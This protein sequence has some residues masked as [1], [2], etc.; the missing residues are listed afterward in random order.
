MLGSSTT[1]GQPTYTHVNFYG[2]LIPMAKAVKIIG[3]KKANTFL[4]HIGPGANVL[5]YP[6]ANGTFCNVTAFIRNDE[7]WPTNSST[8]T[9]GFRKD[10]QTGLKNWNPALRGLIDLFPEQLPMWAVFD[11][12]E[13]P[14]PYY[15]KGR[16]CL[17]GDAAHASSPHHG[18]G[19]GM[20]MEDALC[21]SV[22]MSEVLLALKGGRLS[23]SVAVSTAF[24]VYNDVRRSRSQW[25]VD[26]SRRICD[27]HHSADWADPEKW[28]K[29]ENYLQEVLDRTYKIWNF[30]FFGMA[31]QSVEML[32]RALN[33]LASEQE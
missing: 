12:W 18:A 25:L 22:L 11:L 6:V 1:A 33:R 16:I 10:I 7:E 27:I 17:A 14:V 15:H 13:H 9:I 3:E 32:G 5:H 19:A 28:T 29:A 26:S 23:K 4:N 2:N 31:K 8:T 21:L 30:D 20:G 24:E